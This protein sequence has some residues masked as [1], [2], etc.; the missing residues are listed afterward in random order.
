MKVNTFEI[1]ELKGH[2]KCRLCPKNSKNCCIC[3][4]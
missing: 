4:W 3:V 1:E 2:N